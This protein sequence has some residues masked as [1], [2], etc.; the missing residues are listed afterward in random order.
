LLEFLVQIAPGV[1][2]AL[3]VREMFQR[4]SLSFL[5]MKILS[6]SSL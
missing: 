3:A 5:R 6:A 1:S 4:F 2:I